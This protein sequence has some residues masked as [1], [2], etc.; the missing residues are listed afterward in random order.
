MKIIGRI[1]IILMVAL[2]V[3]GATIAVTN[4]S[5]SA[6]AAQNFQD[7]LPPQI[8]DGNFVPG[9]RPEGSNSFFE[10]IGHLLVI[11]AI[12]LVVVAIER[13]WGKIFKPRPVPVSINQRT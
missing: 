7:G 3:V 8:G 10:S 13:F 2:V 11:A 4:S 1:F 9:Q 6:Q 5:N 12:M